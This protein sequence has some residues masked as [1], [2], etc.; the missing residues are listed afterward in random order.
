MKDLHKEQEY[1]IAEKDQ[2]VTQVKMLRSIELVIQNLCPI[3]D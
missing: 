3:S 1:G 2:R